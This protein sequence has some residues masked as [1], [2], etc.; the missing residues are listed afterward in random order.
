MFVDAVDWV[1]QT[2]IQISARAERTN[3]K[4]AVVVVV[5][6]RGADAPA[7]VLEVKRAR[8]LR[9]LLDAAILNAEAM[10]DGS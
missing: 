7:A 8:A 6:S 4:Q 5:I 1:T 2:K 10:Q 9:S 3:V